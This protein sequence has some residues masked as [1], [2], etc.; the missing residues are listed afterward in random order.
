VPADVA[1]EDVTLGELARRMED[2]REAMREGFE[3]VGRRFD[4][5]AYV[6]SDVF[7]EYRKL[8]DE[9][10]AG[11]KRENT[12]LRGEL[13]AVKDNLRWLV[14]AVVGA[15]VSAVIVAVFAYAEHGPR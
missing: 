13:D 1:A 11:L 10:R 12:T 9:Q 4:D 6:R 2:F 8:A 7:E 15:I 14:R 3:A 5:L